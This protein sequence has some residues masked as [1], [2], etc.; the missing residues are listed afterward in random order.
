[1]KLTIATSSHGASWFV[2][3]KHS[4]VSSSVAELCVQLWGRNPTLSLFFIGSVTN[5][6]PRNRHQ[7]SWMT[8]SWHE[9]YLQVVRTTLT[10]NLNHC[11]FAR[12]TLTRTWN[13]RRVVCTT[14]TCT[15]N[16]RQ[17][18]C[19]SLTRT[20]SNQSWVEN[21]RHLLLARVQQQSW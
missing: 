15:L 18:V 5:K 4:L 13:N 3:S 11:Y 19:A 2:L 10:R 12:T 6:L 21:L 20:L 14:L 17:V 1:M 16:H 9:L 7:D 8:V